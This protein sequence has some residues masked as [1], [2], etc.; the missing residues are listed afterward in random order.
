M[1]RMTAEM[2][3]DMRDRTGAATQTVIGN[4]GRLKKA[5]RDYA[6][7]VAGVRLSQK[8]RAMERVLIARDR[9]IEARRKK[10][11]TL[12]VYAMAGATAA[13]AVGARAV[14]QYADLDRTMSRI[15]ITAEA[16]VEETNAAT[17]ALQGMTKALGLPLD[18]GIAALDTMTA[19]GMNLKEAFK[20]L[21]AVLTTTQATGAAAEDIANAG[22]KV[23]SAFGIGADRMQ[24]AFDQMAFSGKNGQFEL[25]NMANYLPSLATLF[26][27]VGY[28]G[29]DGLKRLLGMLQTLRAQTGTAEEAATYARNILFKMTA[30]QTVKAFKKQNID[31][32]K[33]LDKAKKAGEDRIHAFLRLSL[34]AAGGNIE[35]F[36]KLFTDTEFNIG[37]KIL[38][39]H[40]A[41]LQHNVEILNDTKVD[42]TNMRDAKRIADDTA[43]SI[44]RLNQ[45][46]DKLMTQTGKK[47]A[48]WAVPAMDALSTGM[49]IGE[50]LDAGLKKRGYNWFSRQFYRP[51]SKEEM[52]EVLHEGGYADPE[53]LQEYEKLHPRKRGGHVRPT[54]RL[55]DR[56]YTPSDL[57]EGRDAPIPTP[58]PQTKRGGMNTTDVAPQQRANNPLGIVDQ[59]RARFDENAQYPDVP[60]S[61]PPPPPRFPGADDVGEKLRSAGA[62]VSAKIADGGRAAGDAITGSMSSQA[63]AIGD[64]IGAAAARRFMSSINLPVAPQSLGSRPPMQYGSDMSG[65]HASTNDSGL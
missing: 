61:Y 8:D 53:F 42:G 37:M 22:L 56:G 57:P 35:N 38:A 23:S 18:Q 14:K 13:A 51:T 55:S 30:P 40:M 54:D 34:K 20:F 16:S 9:E 5:E 7:A 32:L 28:K 64:A 15:G 39:Q 36:N 46:F 3:I 27:A 10:L 58:R 63:A 52:M 33:E 62:D 59:Y 1:G 12:G 60:L 43:A 25:K 29:E 11:E 47:V 2:I 44:E 49:S 41:E 17:Q 50:A 65:I 21:P 6:L 31:L 26:S 45:S 4:L 24:A 48:K 19:S